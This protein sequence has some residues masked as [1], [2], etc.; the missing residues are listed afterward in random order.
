MC[1][2]SPS[3]ALGKSCHPLLVQAGQPALPP[4]PTPGTLPGVPARQTFLLSSN[5]GSPAEGAPKLAAFQ[6]K[7]LATGAGQGTS[8]FVPPLGPFLQQLYH[9][10]APEPPASTAIQED[11]DPRRASLPPP[12]AGWPYP[13]PAQGIT[14]LEASGG[15]CRALEDSGGL[16][17]TGVRGAGP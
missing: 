13:S 16:F 4:V 1:S 5:P 17:A 2:V 7:C 3:V 12:A 9:C 6:K 11:R 14:G 8:H 15:V 10:Q